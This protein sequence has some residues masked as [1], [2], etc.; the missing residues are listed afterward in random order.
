M[1]LRLTLALSAA[2][3]LFATANCAGL[4]AN[5]ADSKPLSATAIQGKTLY[6]EP[7]L[8]DAGT[9]LNSTATGNATVYYQDKPFFAKPDTRKEI[10]K[11]TLFYL[12]DK[13][14][15]KFATPNGEQ[16]LFL[17]RTTIVKQKVEKNNMW[18]HYMACF[19]GLAFLCPPAW[20]V[21]VFLPVKIETSVEAVIQIFEIPAAEVM[22]RQILKPGA[23]YPLFNTQGL[24]VLAQGP[25]DT[26]VFMERGFMNAY[27]TD[28]GDLEILSDVYA[29]YLAA[30][31][32]ALIQKSNQGDLANDAPA[33]D[34]NSAPQTQSF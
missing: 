5:I 25:L 1:R 11:Q 32:A 13:M 19:G 28:P 7:L 29:K 22:E 31:V 21:H 15:V 20:L 24:Q 23:L 26:R 17:V 18:I 2:L 12:E 16:P 4:T 6:F 30:E 10:H 34:D 8:E 33:S 14:G 27:L 3:S 9:E